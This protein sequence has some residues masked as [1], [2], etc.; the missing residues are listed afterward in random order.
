MRDE[1]HAQLP[2]QDSVTKVPYVR[3]SARNVGVRRRVLDSLGKCINALS[4]Q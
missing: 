2:V 3:I 1:D 4:H